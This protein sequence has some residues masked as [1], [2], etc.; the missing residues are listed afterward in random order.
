MT[1]SAE[2]ADSTSANGAG[3]LPSASTPGTTGNRRSFK[4]GPAKIALTDRKRASVDV[5]LTDARF[6]AEITREGFEETIRGEVD[7]VAQTVAQTIADAGLRPRDLTA[8]FLT[9]GSTAIPLARRSILSLVPEAAVV[10]GD[11]F[12]SVGLGLALDAVRKFG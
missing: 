4:N 7:R 2:S 11:V 9:G 8:V 6:S 3:R 12:G 1:G 10:E 5:D